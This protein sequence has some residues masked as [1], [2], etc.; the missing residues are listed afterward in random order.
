ME[1]TKQPIKNRNT[2][3]WWI[4]ENDELKKIFKKYETKPSTN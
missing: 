2:L 1:K 4:K 3:D